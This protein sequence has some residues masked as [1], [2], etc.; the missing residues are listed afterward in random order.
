MN[1]PDF[2]AYEFS[3]PALLQLAL[4][5]RSAAKANNERLE[6][7]GD[8]VLGQVIAERLFRQF[9]DADEG[10]LTRSRA[11]LVRKETLARIARELSLGEHIVLGE[12]ELKSGGWRRDSILANT[13]E[14]VIGAIYLDGGHAAC[15]EEIYR[16]FGATLASVD[17]QRSGKDAKT[18]L[19][20]HLQSRGQA[21]P[22][23]SAVSMTGPAH[24]QRFTIECRVD[25]EASPATAT[26][27]SRRAGEQL[28]A[29][30]MLERLEK[31][32]SHA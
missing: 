22:R 20:E 4:T 21:L 30:L 19:Q 12:G 2:L 10:Q 28:A 5:H 24:D 15:T 7:L 8:A 1:V 31:E 13:L 6:F 14:A 23:Y 25:S 11:L 29:Q 16:W 3:D 9:E 17:P 18:R 26:G 27:R 32:S